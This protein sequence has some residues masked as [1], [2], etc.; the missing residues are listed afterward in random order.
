M[1]IK[2]LLLPIAFLLILVGCGTTKN[3]RLRDS[4]K[5]SSQSFLDSIPFEWRFE[6]VVIK[7]QIP[8][9]ERP[10]ELIFDTGASYSVIRKDNAVKSGLESVS[11]I[12]IGDTH[13]NRKTTPIYLFP[14][15]QLGSTTFTNHAA[16]GVNY[17]ED[18]L[19]RCI[20]ADGI[21]GANLMKK[22]HWKIDYTRQM[23]YF[24]DVADS[25]PQSQN[26][27]AQKFRFSGGRPHIDI[28]LNN[29]RISDVLVDT[30]FNGFMDG[31]PNLIPTLADTVT[32]SW[33]YFRKY[34]GSSFGLWGTELDTI[35]RS[36]SQTLMMAD[37]SFW[38][39][40]MEIQSGSGAKMGNRLFKHYDLFLN[41]PD[42]IIQWSKRDTASTYPTK[43][44]WGI[45][46]RYTRT[47]VVV[48]SL[49]EGGPAEKAGIEMGDEIEAL[50]KIPMMQFQGQMCALYEFIRSEK[51]NDQFLKLEVKG[52]GSFEIEKEYFTLTTDTLK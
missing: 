4:T 37:S 31:G 25:L 28:H 13:G 19:L 49:T 46:M 35:Y 1:K 33:S 12:S 32:N 3:I 5:V 38:N 41:F 23:I 44:G 39:F 27:V 34:D 21:L 52:K 42:G 36:P 24:S 50:D 18:N 45:G 40:E 11:N 2:V 29:F 22:L 10:W 15:L 43:P 16:V 20:A 9:E 7:L 6:S 30:G 17:D 51:E 8:G 47:G 26:M 48:A 14:E